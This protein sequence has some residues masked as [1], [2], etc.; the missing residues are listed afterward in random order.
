M[1]RDTFDAIANNINVR[2]N[3]SLLKQELK[4]GNNKHA[5]LFYIGNQYNNM[6]LNLLEHDDAKT[7]KNTASVLGELG[8]QEFLA[9]LYH[10]YLRE[11]KLFVKSAYLNA[12]KELDYRSLM[13]DL[14]KRIEELSGM[15]VS[16][17]NRKHFQEEM[18]ALSDLVVMME[19]AKAHKFVGVKKASDIILLTNRN[20]I[21]TTL[22]QLPATVRARAFN[23]GIQ[24]KTPSLEEILPIRTYQEL[25]FLVDGMKSCPMDV[26]D[27]ADII[28][29]SNFLKF[30]KDRHEG[31]PPF[32]FRLEIKTKMDANKKATFAKRLAATI[33]E[34]T[35]RMLINSTSHYE[36]EL[37]LVENKEGS[38]NILVKLFTLKDER[39]VYRNESVAAS[40]RPVNAALTIAL[41]Q[42]YL[43]EDAQILDPFCGVG[44]M[45]ME[46]HKLVKANTMYG[47]D[48]Y[49]DA[50]KKARMNAETAHQIIHF[51]NRDFFDFTHDYLFDEVVTD[52]P[53]AI[54]KV[55]EEEVKQIYIQFF[56]KIK[57]HLAKDAVMILYS[58]D[59]GL[60]RKYA[61][62]NGFEVVKEYEISMKEGTYVFVIKEKQ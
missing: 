24:A 35:E 60:V 30:L 58:H 22:D 23:A 18:R 41:A 43:K 26:E 11:T 28:A 61:P 13:P 57:E 39:F 42:D 33:E 9:P 15:Y 38:F 62:A 34:K 31:N 55:R 17:E 45:L 37:R 2:Q 40:I 8:K 7:R 48:I 19:G 36:V 27:A 53:F 16:D 4:D 51:I 59:K 5:L 1:I 44:T 10:A 6:F 21:Q 14:K 25:L 52:M 12:I 29:K 3:L 49:G 20:H 54:G 56:R 50:I 46:R 47:I 32:Y